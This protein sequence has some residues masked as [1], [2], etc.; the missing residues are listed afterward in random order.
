MKTD[1]WVGHRFK[2]SIRKTDEFKSF[3]RDFRSDLKKL[4]GDGYKLEEM[5]TGHFILSGFIRNED[6]DKLMYF[7]ASD[8]RFFQDAWHNALLVRTAEALDDYTGGSKSFCKFKEVGEYASR[9]TS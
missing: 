4:I 2:S 1:G 7:S 3:A 6:T 5:T 9:L 8:V